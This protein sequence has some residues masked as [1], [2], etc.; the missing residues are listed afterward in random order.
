MIPIEAKRSFKETLL[1]GGYNLLFGAG[2]SLDSTDHRGKNL[3][4][5]EALREELCRVTGAAPS[6]AM[7]RVAPLLT[8]QQRQSILVE[9]FRGC[10]PGP[11]VSLLSH[12]LWRRAFTFNI[13]DVVE[14]HYETARHP[15]QTL[16][17]INYDGPFQPTPER[18][19]LHLVHLHGFAREPDTPFVFSAAEYARVMRELNPWMHMLAEIL[20]T[21]PFIIAGTTLNEVDLAFYLNQRSPQTPRRSTGPSLLIEPYPDVATRADCDRYGLLLVEATFGDFLAWLHDTVPTPPTVNDLLVPDST[22]LFDDAVDKKDLLRFFSDFELVAAGDQPL[23]RAPTPFFYGRE[24]TWVE[25][26]QHVDIFRSAVD[27]LASALEDHED[28]SGSI[29]IVLGDPGVG[30]STAVR[31]IAHTRALSGQ[32]VFSVRT[33]A[34]LDLAAAERCLESLRARALLLV[35]RIA[36]QASQIAELVSKPKVASQVSVLGAERAYRREYLELHFA[37]LGASFVELP[38]FAEPDYEQLI[39]RYRAFGLIGDP[40]ALQAPRQFARRLTEDVVAVAVCRILNDWRPFDAIVDSLWEATSAPLRDAY[41][42]VALAYHCHGAGLYYPIV[43]ATSGPRAPVGKLLD[44]ESPL[45]LTESIRETDYVVPINTAVAE[46]LVLRISRSRPEKM[47]QVF[48][49]LGASLAPYVNR[50]TIIAR[51]PEARLAGRLFNADSVVRPLLASG[52]GAFYSAM[53][54]AWEWNSRYWEQRA[55]SE[56][57]QDLDLSLRYARH[58]VSVEH[59]PFPLTTLGKVLLVTMDADTA[60]RDEAYAEA[61]EILREAIELERQ[62]SRV[63]VH[64]FMSLI[65]GTTRYLE[66]G[67]SLSERQFQLVERYCNEAETRFRPDPQLERH[68]RALDEQL[69]S[70]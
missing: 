51:S 21:E 66:L 56:L 69:E 34:G 52:A 11:S 62:K 32:P 25:L 3:P 68:L 41:L 27:E 24:P 36:D 7:A 18:H 63:S 38:G 46:R 60:L 65:S 20:A 33:L 40:H 49:Q 13:D 64:P 23:P 48:V 28:G 26:H 1:S 44:A 67:G 54:E 59:H 22:A 30:K 42:C 70:T 8:D 47:Q 2:I 6:T 37:N 16:E 10:T 29:V 35:D 14:G 9:R 50:R 58:A 19:R 31:R 45:R 57:E 4:R 17:P 43:Q 55:L 15:K 39:E 61:I 53:Q 12:Y 5:A